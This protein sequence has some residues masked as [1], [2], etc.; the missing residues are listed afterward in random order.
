MREA[1]NVAVL[2]AKESA[3]SGITGQIKVRASEVRWSTL[4]LT[5]DLPQG[6]AYSWSGPSD[7][8]VAS[9][10]SGILNSA[11]FNLWQAGLK[12]NNYDSSSVICLTVWNNNPSRSVLLAQ[13]CFGCPR[14]FIVWYEFQWFFFY[15]YENWDGDF[16]W[17]LVEFISWFWEDGHFHKSHFYTY[18]RMGCLSTSS[19]VY[20][21]LSS[22]I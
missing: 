10:L 21:S 2:L 17:G 14:Y 5:G 20:P 18:M 16:D 3:A 19:D 4:I 7:I 22:E 9:S 11:D 1:W 15:F 6:T 12:T 8:I 13:D